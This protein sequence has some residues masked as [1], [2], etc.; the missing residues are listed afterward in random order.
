VLGQIQHPAAIEGL[1]KALCNTKLNCM[2]RHEAAESLGAV[3]NEE[4]SS[5]FPCFLYL[6]WI[7]NFFSVF[8]FL[9]LSSVERF[10]SGCIA[11]GQSIVLGG[12]GHLR[13]SSLGP[14]PIRQWTHAVSFENFEKRRHELGSS[15][16]L[17]YVLICIEYVGDLLIVSYFSC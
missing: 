4:V 12:V 9:G 5:L 1:K 14:V 7:S 8:T 3:A 2:V 15:S 6:Y 13:L 17:E 10:H 16:F 11:A